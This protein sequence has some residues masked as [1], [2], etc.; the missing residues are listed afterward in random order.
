MQFIDFEQ[1]SH[2]QVVCQSSFESNYFFESTVQL[3]R[4][5]GL[6]HLNPETLT[7]IETQPFNQRSL[8]LLLNFL[9]LP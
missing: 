4:T 1:L 7:A 2:Y 9:Q 3:C 8:V 6:L 5:Y